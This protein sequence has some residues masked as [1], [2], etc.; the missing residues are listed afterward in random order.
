MISTLGQIIPDNILP[1]IP[2]SRN[3][4]AV[5]SSI[6]LLVIAE[7]SAMYLNRNHFHIEE[8]G[9]Y[10]TAFCNFTADIYIYIYPGEKLEALC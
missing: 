8:S 6:H 5:N 9:T 10:I 1:Y 7:T 3:S 2:A 4:T